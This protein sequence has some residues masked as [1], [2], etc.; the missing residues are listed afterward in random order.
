MTTLR[1][2]AETHENGLK[3]RKKNYFIWIYYT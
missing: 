3:G 1:I 2:I